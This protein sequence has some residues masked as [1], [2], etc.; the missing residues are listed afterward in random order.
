MDFNI[1]S[2]DPTDNREALLYLKERQGIRFTKVIEGVTV[3]A[4]S[5]QL[6]KG[7]PTNS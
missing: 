2:Q 1:V 7:Q 4:N 3:F 5:H 6:L